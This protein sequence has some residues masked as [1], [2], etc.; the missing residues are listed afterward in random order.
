MVRIGG[1]DDWGFRYLRSGFGLST[2]ATF[3]IA[4]YL[5]QL[6]RLPA[7]Y[8]YHYYHFYRA[9]VP[10]ASIGVSLPYI[11]LNGPKK[12]CRESQRASLMEGKAF[13]A[14]E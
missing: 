7:A 9:L 4:V 2:T 1:V 5:Y 13:Q 14:P 6:P 10:S 12:L 8:Y 3:S 11:T